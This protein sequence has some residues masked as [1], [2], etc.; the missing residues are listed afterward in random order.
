MT[1]REFFG[2]EVY[3][4]DI[5]FGGSFVGLCSSWSYQVMY[6][7]YTHLL[8]INHKEVFFKDVVTIALNYIK[9]KL[10]ASILLIY[11]AANS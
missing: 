4:C 1:G 8:Y 2:S 3:I 5:D 7:K 6:I 9:I 11:F 10:E